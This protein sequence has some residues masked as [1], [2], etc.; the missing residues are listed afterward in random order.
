MTI[1]HHQTQPQARTKAVSSDSWPFTCQFRIRM[2]KTYVDNVADV[3]GAAVVGHTETEF[4]AGDGQVIEACVRVMWNDK[5][6]DCQHHYTVVPK[7]QTKPK[8]TTTTTTKI[9]CSS[10]TTTTTHQ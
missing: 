5:K 2:V 1:I 3:L 4:D 6:E 7:S 9:G 8:Q 10:C